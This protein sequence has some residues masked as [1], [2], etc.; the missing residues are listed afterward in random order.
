MRNG[1]SVCSLYSS[2]LCTL[3]INTPIPFEGSPKESNPD[4]WAEEALQLPAVGPL[5]G[6]ARTLG[7]LLAQ[8]LSPVHLGL[9]LPWLVPLLM[10]SALQILAL[11]AGV[12]TLG[13]TASL[14]QPI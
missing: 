13:F 1:L 14:G 12:L 9:A 2:W 6:C 3:K 4:P 8:V 5:C 10:C 7:L 11:A